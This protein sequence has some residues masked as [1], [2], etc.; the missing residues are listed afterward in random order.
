M[1]CGE[2]LAIAGNTGSSTGRHLHIGVSVKGEWVEPTAWTGLP[3][4]KGTYPGS[5]SPEE[6]EDDMTYL[7]DI[8]NTRNNQVFEK[9]DVNGPIIANNAATGLYVV[10]EPKVPESANYSS[11][12]LAKIMY[13]NKVAYM[14]Y[15][16]VFNGAARLL[17]ASQI[18]REYGSPLATGGVSQA[19]YDAAVKRAEAAEVAEAQAEAERD[20]AKQIAADEK[21]RADALQAK[22][23]NAKTVKILEG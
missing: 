8:K 16:D 17:E 12:D 22:F 3:N 6:S 9:P 5:D 14:A 4:K 7:L 20:A 18:A 19:D 11:F 2:K 13:G 23:D 10:I 1:K 21:E 15:G